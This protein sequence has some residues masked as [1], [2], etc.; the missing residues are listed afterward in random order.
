MPRKKNEINK[1]SAENLKKWMQNNKISNRKLAEVLDLDHENT[2]SYWKNGKRAIDNFYIEK[3]SSIYGVRKEFLLGIDSYETECIKN[4]A[5]LKSDYDS[6]GIYDLFINQFIDSCE[7]YDCIETDEIIGYINSTNARKP[8]YRNIELLNI[9]LNGTEYLLDENQ[10]AQIKADIEKYAI[11]RLSNSCSSFY[12]QNEKIYEE[13]I[14]NFKKKHSS[15]TF[16]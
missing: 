15:D 2:V 7:T 8:I 16:S 11:F 1:K 3:I 13:V 5:L 10:W 14:E 4:Y 6:W 12:S 9:K